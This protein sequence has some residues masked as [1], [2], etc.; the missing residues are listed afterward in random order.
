M[1][2]LAAGLL[3]LSNMNPT[4]GSTRPP[5]VGRL[6]QMAVTH[7]DP[8]PD[9]SWRHR[10]VTGGALSPSPQMTVLGRPGT[11]KGALAKRLVADAMRSWPVV[12]IDPHDEYDV[13]L[14]ELAGYEPVALSKH[15]DQ[16]IN[17]L[18]VEGQVD[19]HSIV[20]RVTAGEW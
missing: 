20:S 7:P 15:V 4:V 12:V 9:V 17:P 6:N 1:S 11:G 14:D 13:L 10:S 8:A 2:D 3:L 19:A 5:L 18:I 16:V